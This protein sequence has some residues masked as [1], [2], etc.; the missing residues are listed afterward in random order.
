M[1]LYLTEIN[2]QIERD[3]KAFVET[4]DERFHSRVVEA[5]DSIADNLKNSPI[6]LLSGPSG[7][8]KTTT[9]LK[10]EEQ[11]KTKGIRT[12]T[13]SMDDY[14]L[15]VD[16]DT[17]PR[18]ENG[19]LDFESPLCVDMEL[20]NRHFDMLARGE[21]ILIPKFVFSRQRRDVCR[22]KPLKLGKDEVV[23]F[24]GIH[25]LNDILTDRHPSAHKMYIS[26]R[27]D[28]VNGD[29]GVVFKGTWLRLVRRCVRDYN[30]RGADIVITLKMWENVR[31][32]EKKYISP[33][34]L[35]ADFIFDSSLAYEVSVMKNYARPFLENLPE[36]SPREGEIKRMLKAFEMFATIELD[37][38]PSNSLLREFIGGSAYHDKKVTAE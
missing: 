7:S 35:K 30:F 1:P 10:I 3:P 19:D 28:V 15:N 24:E 17:S 21:E 36:G 5:A 25:A 29:G 13:V 12:N 26:A 31:R 2:S 4:T 18:D 37:L 9:A 20:M 6:V 14:F 38:V 22:S 33:Y 11:L 32:G 34:K 8:G 27:S 16:P 23:I